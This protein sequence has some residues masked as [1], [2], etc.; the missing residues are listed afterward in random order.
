[1]RMRAAFPLRTCKLLL[2]AA[3]AAG[4]GEARA[5]EEEEEEEVVPGTRAS[6]GAMGS[7]RSGSC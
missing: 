1:M 6:I 5:A 7:W 4:E 3:A 2:E